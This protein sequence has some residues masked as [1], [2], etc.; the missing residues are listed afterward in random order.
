MVLP[1]TKKIAQIAGLAKS[2]SSGAQMPLRDEL[3][4]I[5]PF[6]PGNPGLINGLLERFHF[7]AD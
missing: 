7:V 1:D 2:D 4:L 6:R 5:T 3:G